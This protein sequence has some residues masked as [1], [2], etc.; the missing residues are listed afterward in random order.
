[1]LLRTRDFEEIPGVAVAHEEGRTG[2]RGQDVEPGGRE[3][4][5]RLH[6][7][8]GRRRRRQ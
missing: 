1:V 7:G 8:H 3:V 4:V 5:S 6:V 2:G